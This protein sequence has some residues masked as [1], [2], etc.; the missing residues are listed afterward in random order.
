MYTPA[1]SPSKWYVPSAAVT[2]VA[3]TRLPGPSR[4]TVTLGAPASPTITDA[5]AVEVDEHPAADAGR[6]GV[7]DRRSRGGDAVGDGDGL[8]VGRGGLV[9]VDRELRIGLVD[10]DQV[11][12]DR[13]VRQQIGAGGVGAHPDRA[14]GP[15]EHDV[16]VRDRLIGAVE[17][18]VAVHVEEHEPGEVTDRLHLDV[19]GRRVGDAVA[20]PV[21]GDDRGRV[22]EVDDDAR[23][24]A[25]PGLEAADG[26][27]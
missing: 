20:E 25:R 13:R 12:A 15:G 14:I 24:R 21:V 27:R 18:P 5:V 17:H 26:E 10:V 8:A 2:V 19:G 16:D 7:P 4:R 3:T 6:W 11:G 1:R 23:L 22:G 9:R